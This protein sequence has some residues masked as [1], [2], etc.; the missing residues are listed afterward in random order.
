MVFLT[1]S[2]G[3]GGGIVL[4]GRLLGGL[5]GSFGL[6]ESPSGG[7]APLEDEVSGR[8]IAAEAERRGQRGGARRCLPRPPAARLGR[9]DPCRLVIPRHTA[10][11]RYP[12]DA[13]PGADRHRWRY[14]VGARLSRPG[15]GPSEA[16][17]S[18]RARSGSRQARAIGG[19]R[20][21]CRSRQPAVHPVPGFP[22]IEEKEFADDTQWETCGRRLAGSRHGLADHLERHRYRARLAG[23]LGGDGAARTVAAY[24]ARPDVADADKVELIFFNRDGFYDK[25]QADMAAGS[26]AFDVNLARHLFASAVTPPTW[27]RS[28][29]GADAAKVFGESGAEDH[30]VRRQAVWRADRPVAAL[31][32]LPQGPD[33]RA[34]E[35]RGGQV[36]NMPRSPRSSSARSCSRRIP[37]AGPGTTGRL[38]R[39][40]SPRRS[41][42]TARYATAPCCR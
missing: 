6:L 40:I 31:H 42:P 18:R 36:R 15:A 11:P 13:R 27:S 8:L 16:A 22:G 38:P 5:A 37:T 39:S 12:A 4:G 21:G 7:A 26:D 29:V 34:D 17:W 14:R 41:I 28:S 32:V 20:R 10:L 19:D 3:I 9:G 30:A 25:L 35:G 1:I 33:R 2:T 24:N 23:R